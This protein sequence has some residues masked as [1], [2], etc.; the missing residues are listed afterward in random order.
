MFI[1]PLEKSIDWKRPPVV[2]FLLVLINCVVL[3]GFQTDDDM[4]AERALD[5]YLASA[6]PGMEFPAYLEFAHL[7]GRPGELQALGRA[8]GEDPS[9]ARALLLRME[10]DDEFMDALGAGRV[11][12]VDHPHHQ[13]WLTQ[14]REYDELKREAFSWRYGFVPAEHR[15]VTFF[16]HMFLHG[17]F[18]HLLGNMLVLV[19]VGL[20]MELALG[21]SLYVLLY[22]GGG[23]AAVS[24]FWLV[25]PHSVIPLVGASGAIAGL[26]GLYATVFGLRKIRFFY[27]VLFY[28][29]Y[30]RAPAILMLPL[31]LLNEFYQLY[32]GGMSNVAYVAHIGGLMFG[33]AA[34]LVLRRMPVRVDTAYLDESES[35]DRRDAE[36]QRG[37]QLLSGLAVGKAQ[38]VFRALHAEFPDDQAVLLQLYKAE[39]LSPTSPEFHAVARKVIALPGNDS[40][41]TREVRDAFLDYLTATKGKIRLSPPQLMELAMRFTRA[42]HLDA[43]ERIVHPLVRA[44]A[45]LPGLERAVMAL[46]NGWRRANQPDK[47][48]KSMALLARAFPDSNMVQDG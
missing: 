25:H 15:P 6:L 32:W 43:A 17:G 11:I 34:G 7:R 5:H 1:I 13:Q 8:A 12:E 22:L 38:A 46:A 39:K 24:L 41:T 26:M 36:F 14:R 35:R 20:A 3:F 9:A 29:D 27:S 30:V 31:W 21:S 44:K 42:G 16:S 45:Q 33:G 10:K 37:L 48:Q 19:I 4:A 18:G 40:A 47:H 23:L 28:F 2:T